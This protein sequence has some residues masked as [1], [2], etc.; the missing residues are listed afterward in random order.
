VNRGLVV[1]DCGWNWKVEKVLR[2]QRRFSILET[3]NDGVRFTNSQLRSLSEQYRSLRERYNTVQAAIAEEVLAIAGGYAEPLASLSS[4][5]ARIDVLV[6]FSHVSASAPTPYVRPSLSAMGEGN[7]ELK[8]C[9]HPCMEQQDDIS[10]ISNDV[11]LIREED[12]FQIITGP[13]M[14]GKSTYIRQVS[15]FLPRLHLASFCFP[16]LGGCGCV[17]GTGGLLCSLLLCQNMCGG[18]YSGESRGK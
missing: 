4:L 8:D 15:T 11:S 1:C 2:G 9:R 6:S 5:L 3:R 17:D 12:M 16:G 18:P 13:N 14:G 7:I 10:F